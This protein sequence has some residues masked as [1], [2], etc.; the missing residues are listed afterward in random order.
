MSC[1]RNQ[2]TSAPPLCANNCGF[3]GVVAQRN[4]CSKCYREDARKRNDAVVTNSSSVSPPSSSSSSSSLFQQEQHLSYPASAI[5]TSSTV[6]TTLSAEVSVSP[7]DSISHISSNTATAVLSSLGLPSTSPSS[8][9]SPDTSVLSPPHA[10]SF[11][12]TS[13]VSSSLAATSDV[14]PP[15]SAAAHSLQDAVAAPSEALSAAAGQS[16]VAAEIPERTIQTN[17]GRCWCCQAKI[18]LLGFTC[19]CGYLFCGKHR[20]ADA[21]DCCFDYKAYDRQNLAKNNNRV[22][23]EKLERI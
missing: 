20:Y 1:E 16:E 17:R 14:F 19:R 15:S 5:D 12:S 18:G 11:S 8:L 23:A 4:L 2:Q 13:A 3:Y 7:T 22:V 6:C 21:H 10:S 9:G